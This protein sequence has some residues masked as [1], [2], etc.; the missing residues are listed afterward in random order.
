MLSWTVTCKTEQEANSFAEMLEM[1]LACDSEV[2]VNGIEVTV[3]VTEEIDN[4]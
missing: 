1:G 2:T 3:T 4:G